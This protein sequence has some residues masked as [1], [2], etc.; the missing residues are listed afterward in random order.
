MPFALMRQKVPMV[1]QAFLFTKSTRILNEVTLIFFSIKI[2]NQFLLKSI[3]LKKRISSV[4]AF[5]NIRKCK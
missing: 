4:A 1:E 3:Y 2:L 5:I